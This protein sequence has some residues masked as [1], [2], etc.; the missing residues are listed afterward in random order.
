MIRSENR[1]V[2]FPNAVFRAGIMGTDHGGMGLT[3]KV[4]TPERLLPVMGN[5]LAAD[6]SRD[7]KCVLSV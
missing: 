4:V 2:I 5:Y 3:I 7:H 1:F 6:S